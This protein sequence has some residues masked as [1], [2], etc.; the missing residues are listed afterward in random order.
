MCTRKAIVSLLVVLSVL[1]TLFSAPHTV[2]ATEPSTEE[3]FIE[4]NYETREETVFTWRM[5][6]LIKQPIP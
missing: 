3:T 4:I 6:Y 5:F 2:Y 1:L